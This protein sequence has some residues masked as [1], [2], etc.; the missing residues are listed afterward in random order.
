MSLNISTH[1]NETRNIFV[2]CLGHVSLGPILPFAETSP[3]QQSP[4][5]PLKWKKEVIPAFLLVNIFKKDLS[6]TDHDLQRHFIK[7]RP[8]DQAYTLGFIY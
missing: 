5:I 8:R 6:R 7:V 1:S 4:Y 2:C 3:A